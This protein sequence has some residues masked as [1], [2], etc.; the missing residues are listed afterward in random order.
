MPGQVPTPQDTGKLEPVLPQWLKDARESARQSQGSQT[1]PPPTQQ[2]PPPQ[3]PPASNIDFLAGLQSQASEDEEEDVPDWLANITGGAPKAAKV[4]PITET[5][6]ARWVEMGK[7]DDFAS[8]D[9]STNDNEVPSWLADLQSQSPKADEKDELTNWFGE[10]DQA[11][12]VQQ[13]GIF[14]SP[15]PREETPDWLRNL[16]AEA[17]AA[18]DDEATDWLKQLGSENNDSQSPTASSLETPDW[19]SQLGTET[20]AAAQSPTPIA[21]TFDSPETPDWLS[22]LDT[23]NNASTQA[24]PSTASSFETPDWLSQLGTETPAAT[25]EQPATDSS[26]ETPDWLS[27][28]G[29]AAVASSE[30][31]AAFGE[32]ASMEAEA[33]SAADDLPS[34]LKEPE[35]AKKSD[36]TPAWLKKQQGGTGV[37]T[38]AWMAEDDTLRVTDLRKTES[39]VEETPA[40]EDFGDLPDWLKSAAPQFS[41]FD[42]P[43]AQ[44][45][46]NDVQ[47]DIPTWLEAAKPVEIAATEP[48][49]S[50][51]SNLPFETF[52]AFTTENDS[53]NNADTLFTDMP[54]WLSSAI[55]PSSSA[56]TPFN[57]GDALSPSELPSWVEAMRPV[58]PTPAG[59]SLPGLGDQPLESRGALAGLTGVLP[60]GSGFTPTSK[61]K[62]YS[63]KLNASEEQLKNAN[64]L[65]QILAAETA[66]EPLETER[67]LGVS[68]TLRWSFAAILLIVT[69]TTAILGSQFFATPRAVP[70]EISYTKAI[71]EAVPEGV[72]VL[73]ALD[74][75][76][77]RV[78][79]MESAIV[80]VLDNF[81]LLKHP[82]LTFVSSNESGS[83]LAE[84]LI[85]GP[86][87][88]RYQTGLP[89]QNLGYLPGGQLGIRAFA[90]GPATAASVDISMNP[91]WTSGPGWGDDGIKLND[92]AVIL[93]ITDSADAARAWVEQTQDVRGSIPFLVISSA[94]AAPMIQPY[95]SS[96][97]INGM[98]SGVYGGAIYEAQYNRPG[99]ARN[100]WDAYSI[101]ML[102][103]MVVVLGGGL[104]NLAL[105]LRDRSSSTKRETS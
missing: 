54:D 19:L 7:K 93:L 36:T 3:Q 50:D 24:Q 35:E 82:Y 22:R 72:P 65:E 21:S 57:S 95:Y 26:F 78:G 90:L 27:G 81:L 34:W 91:A 80:P 14:D 71:L 85:S 17:K 68:R 52:P 30:D 103:A 4:D 97:Q 96:V 12:P 89:Y 31:Q 69:F 13:A 5:S 59:V 32:P 9:S 92:F 37:D 40:Q 42:E 99:I 11:E 38:P 51:A 88:E 76:P 56:P 100:Y 47:P 48:P 74:Y 2:T 46:G 62:A 98:V 105:G 86:L 66:P 58:E 87:A 1:P 75:E 102:L 15:Q 44:P 104:F 10:S 83:M 41:I 33:S 79:E 63:I 84:R 55:E 43:Q 45:V 18:S 53:S 6:G 101:G 29:S 60:A 39:S 25:P 77:S 94:Q 8:Q 23:E 70:A 73:V 61:P 20:P 16:E 67:T 64:I 28:L 49:H